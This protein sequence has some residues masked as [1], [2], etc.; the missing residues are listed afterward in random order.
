LGVPVKVLYRPMSR[1]ADEQAAAQSDLMVL[2]ERT[3]GS[4]SVVQLFGQEEQNDEAFRRACDRSVRTYLAGI[5]SQLVFKLGTSGVT[6]IG[7]A[8]IMLFGGM[9]VLNGAL[10]LGSL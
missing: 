8:A 10:T 4:I 2:G 1:R 6:A 3:F 7:T 5:V 9:H